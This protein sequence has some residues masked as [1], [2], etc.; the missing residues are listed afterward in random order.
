MSCRHCTICYIS[1]NATV[2]RDYFNKSLLV[3]EQLPIDLRD[4]FT[5]IR[6][7]DLQVQS[8]F[9]DF[10]HNRSLHWLDLSLIFADGIDDL[11]MKVREFLS[12]AATATQEWRDEYYKILKQVDISNKMF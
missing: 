8:K 10:I 6:E 2:S 12:N 3:I 1:H 5:E 9:Y 4:R 7:M 11:E